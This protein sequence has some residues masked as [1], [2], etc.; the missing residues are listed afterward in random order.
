MLDFYRTVAG[1]TFFEGTLPRIARALEALAGVRGVEA[2][3]TRAHPD[4]S[5]SPP[6]GDGWRP[7]GVAN[8][9]S[10]VLVLWERVKP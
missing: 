10:G 6:E 9:G 3:V 5:C 1:R 8:A 2:H 4:G 7:V